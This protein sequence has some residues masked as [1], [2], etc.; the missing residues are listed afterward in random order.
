MPGAAHPT[1]PAHGSSPIQITKRLTVMRL[2][3]QWVQALFLVIAASAAGCGGGTSDGSR[4][5]ALAAGGGAAQPAT[6]QQKD[7]AKAEV[8]L[9]NVSFD[10]T[11]ELYAEFNPEFQKH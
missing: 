2:R 11:R 8:Q 7:A 3:S 6:S 1:T 4:G 9:L 5:V 10:P